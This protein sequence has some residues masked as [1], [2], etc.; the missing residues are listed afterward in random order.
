MSSAV[1]CILCRT[2]T[3][4]CAPSRCVRASPPC[5]LPPG[6]IACG[7]LLQWMSSQ[8]RISDADL[9]RSQRLARTGSGT[10]S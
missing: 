9:V 1:P 6:V 3:C 8:R 4:L 5:S 10:A 7:P 2:T